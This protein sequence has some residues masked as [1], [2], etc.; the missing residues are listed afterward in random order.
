MQSPDPK[1]GMR[2]RSRHVAHEVPVGLARVGLP[3]GA[4]VDGDRRGAGV[5]HAAGDVRRAEI[6]LVPPLAHLD[7]DR[8]ANRAGH[9]P[10]DAGG[11]RGIAHQ[12]AAGLVLRNLRHRAPHVDVDDVR[13]HA[14]DDASGLG[15]AL[16]IAAED[17]DRDRTLFFG[18][19]RVLERAIDAANQALA[20][21]HLGHDQ[22]ASALALHQAAEGGVGH[23]GHRRHDERRGERHRTNLHGFSRGTHPRRPLRRSRRGEVSGRLTAGLASRAPPSASRRA[24]T[25]S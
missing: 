8:N 23:A 13:A 24:P 25:P 16:G 18:V 21:H 5:L 22:A 3:R 1:T 19:L 14:F 12:A 9:R 15:H 17:L 10:H 2:D 4:A 6:R 7:R 11:V 20:A